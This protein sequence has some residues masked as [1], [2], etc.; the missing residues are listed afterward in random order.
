MDVT[1]YL[2]KDPSVT[3]AVFQLPGTNAIAAVDGVRK[4]MEEAKKQ[5]VRLSYRDLSLILLTSKDS[6]HSLLTGLEAGADPQEALQAMQDI[7]AWLQAEGDRMIYIYGGWDPWTG[8]AVELTG[9]ATRTDWLRRPLAG[10]PSLGSWVTYG[11]GT[12][13]QNLPAFVVLTDPDGLPVEIGE[14]F[15]VVRHTVER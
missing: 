3:M 2:D 1:S 9:E 6:R 14:L 10:R 12:V 13:S 4:L 11:L 15:D 8:C 5:G 7:V